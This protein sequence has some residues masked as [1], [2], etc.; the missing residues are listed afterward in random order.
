MKKNGKDNIKVKYIRKKISQVE[1][2]I[3]IITENNLTLSR[4][5]YGSSG[6]I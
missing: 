4:T 3:R 6:I 1:R 5:N 2:E